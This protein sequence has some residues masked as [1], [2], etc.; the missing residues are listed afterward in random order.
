MRR[1]LQPQ[2]EASVAPVRA[3][4]AER[5]ISTD[6]S[7]A[8]R[9]MAAHIGNRADA[10][11]LPARAA[12][13]FDGR[14]SDA[15]KPTAAEV[16]GQLGAG[17]PIP[18][19]VAERFGDAY[20]ASLDHVQFHPESPVPVRHGANALTVGHHVAFA[21]GRFTP[22]TA[23]GQELIGH[24][25]A[26]VVQ[27][28]DGVQAS[29]WD[30][31][32]LEQEADAASLAVAAGHSFAIGGDRTGGVGRRV[33][34]EDGKRKPVAYDP[35][36]SLDMVYVTD[37]EGDI[38]Y[39][40]E[41]VA[42]QILASADD[43]HTL[44]HVHTN[45]RHAF[46][47]DPKFLN[48][49]YRSMYEEARGQSIIRPIPLDF[50]LLKGFS[51][52][53][54][55]A[56]AIP[57]VVYLP[58]GGGGGIFPGE[59]T[60]DPLWQEPPKVEP[61][62]LEGYTPGPSPESGH[63]PTVQYG[64]PIGKLADV[65]RHPETYDNV[66]SQPDDTRFV[67]ILDPRSS[68]ERHLIASR[69]M[70]WV[71][72]TEPLSLTLITG[73]GI[74]Q[75]PLFG[76]YKKKA[77][78]EVVGLPSLS[79]PTMPLLQPQGSGLPD[80]Q[81]LRQALTR[82]IGKS[83][84]SSP[85]PLIQG[86]SVVVTL[87]YEGPIVLIHP[88]GADG[89]QIVGTA[90]DQVTVIGGVDAKRA[91]AQGAAGYL[92]TGGAQV[93]AFAGLVRQSSE[94]DQLVNLDWM[95]KLPSPVVD[96]Q[97]DP[98]TAA[99]LG[100]DWPAPTAPRYEEQALRVFTVGELRDMVRRSQTHR[101]LDVAN[102]GRFSK[103]TDLAATDTHVL[104]LGF[105]QVPIVDTGTKSPALDVEKDFKPPTGKL[106]DDAVARVLDLFDIARALLQGNV[107]PLHPDYAHLLTSLD[108]RLG[109]LM[110]SLKAEG[111]KKSPDPVTVAKYERLITVQLE[112]M[113]SASRSI[114]QI[115]ALRSK[116]GDFW[117][118]K[119]ELEEIEA[120]YVLALAFSDRTATAGGLFEEARERLR[121]FPIMVITVVA[122]YQNRDIENTLQHT[123]DDSWWMGDLVVPTRSKMRQLSA[124]SQNQE[125]VEL[126]S[127][128]KRAGELQKEGK[129][130]EAQELIQKAAKIQESM[131]YRFAV[132]AQLH[133]ALLA[134]QAMGNSGIKYW[135]FTTNTDERLEE[136]V[137]A[138]KQ[139]LTEFEATTDDE[140]RKK[141]GEKAQKILERPRYQELY[142]DV[143]SAMK[144]GDIATGIV[145]TVIAALATWGIASGVGAVVGGS[146]L[147]GTTT[148]ALLVFGAEVVTFTAADRALMSVFMDK[149]EMHKGLVGFE[150]PQD[151]GS[152]WLED[153]LTNAAMLGMLKGVG[154]IWSGLGKN[155]GK[156]R[157]FAGEM[158]SVAAAMQT[159]GYF[160]H[161]FKTGKPMGFGQ[162][163]EMG[164]TN[165]V[166]LVLM[167]AAGMAARPL[168][169]KSELALAKRVGNYDVLTRG[170]EL[171][172][173]E[174][175]K[176]LRDAL[177]QAEKNG[178]LD[179]GKLGES[180]AEL[181]ELQNQA[182]ELRTQMAADPT[183]KEILARDPKLAESWRGRT[184]LLDTRVKVQQHLL[185]SNRLGLDP[186][187]DGSGATFNNGMSAEVA[188]FY[189]KQGFDV[190][191]AGKTPDGQRKLVATGKDGQKILLVEGRTSQNVELT[192]GF[193]R[194]SLW[195]ARNV[196]KPREDSSLEPG[197]ALVDI[198]RTP[199]GRVESVQVRHHPDVPASDVAVH[200]RAAEMFRSWGGLLGKARQLLDSI[201]MRPDRP[202]HLEIEAWKLH[203]SI[204]VRMRQMETASP[205]Q[206]ARLQGEKA[207]LQQQLDLVQRALSDPS[208]AA[209]LPKNRI[210]AKLEGRGTV[211]EPGDPPT[212]HHWT[213]QGT[214]LV[215]EP[216]EGY[217]GPRLQA[218][219]SYEHY[220][221]GTRTESRTSRGEKSAFTDRFTNTESVTMSG[222]LGKE[223]NAETASLL[224][225]LGYDVSGND[226]RARS[227]LGK[228]VY[229]E[230]LELD[231]SGK[232]Q[233]DHK[234]SAS[235]HPKAEPIAG[236]PGN[237]KLRTDLPPDQIA[238]L[239]GYPEPPAGGT[240]V[241]NRV[242]VS[243]G[244]TR[245]TL[246]LQKGR[247]ADKTFWT[248]DT[249]RG[250][251][252]EVPAAGFQAKLT[253]DGRKNPMR[254]D[255]L[256]LEAVGQGYES[257]KDRP[258]YSYDITDNGTIVVRRT[259]AAK[260]EGQP[261]L[262]IEKDPDV[263]GAYRITDTVGEPMYGA[264][265]REAATLQTM[266]GVSADLGDAFKAANTDPQVKAVLAQRDAALQRRRAAALNAPE[267]P[268]K[269]KKDSELSPKEK[270]DL[271]AWRA[272]PRVQQLKQ[273]GQAVVT[274]SEQLAEAASDAWVAV[275]F[276]G[277]V[278]L[279]TMARSARF[280]EFDRVYAWTQGEKTWIIIAECKGGSSPL[281]SRK[282]GVNRYEQGTK[283][284]LEDVALAMKE[285]GDLLGERIMKAL[286]EKRVISILVRAKVRTTIDNN[287]P[288]SS[289]EGVDVKVFDPTQMKNPP[290]KE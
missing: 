6:P 85:P 228:R 219:Y 220:L 173:R 136:L 235:E 104:G 163:A 88:T 4:I 61:L 38:S 3:K 123:G 138:L 16:A 9:T 127:L 113:G 54:L 232:I 213:T 184:E 279:G 202:F 261:K 139:I 260:A 33:Q 124:K 280:G 247:G 134:F 102:K 107:I 241:L 274:R 212:G 30:E 209:K 49:T 273:E 192:R 283:R 177:E 32:A 74:V 196:G 57:T 144:W 169:L 289:Y 182:A 248:Y 40:Q 269:G 216:N 118:L 156:G 23:Q 265:T 93:T 158:L 8:A 255:P 97:S 211:T 194:G 116:F 128:L 253:A 267:R 83:T 240:W 215:L 167:H 78:I 234:R 67:V 133:Q 10:P 36:L 92:W 130:K 272:D 96:Q 214:K 217:T 11:A 229:L 109:T 254:P 114:Q 238:R 43:A 237:P 166:A 270:S 204:D 221:P 178:K 70:R 21:P 117:E 39:E 239:L 101:L 106:D 63:D 105:D 224:G 152:G 252:V 258:G 154:R 132:L 250:D 131:Q 191:E 266:P 41:R 222:V 60:F 233:I 190:S 115:P 174:A 47:F 52:S 249:V 185:E 162:L 126:Q 80:L 48:P 91:M 46:R 45:D 286:E 122:K 276:P 20:G 28:T 186:R 34:L 201:R 203:E 135:Q 75:Q 120:L 259:D 195:K 37:W 290:K 243:G 180:M 31:G 13:Q 94:P 171:R 208:L 95:T 257:L 69:T 147:A 205:Q 87:G 27:Q 72:V 22:G 197:E 227:G 15:P 198:I 50:S 155:M 151:E 89:V 19:A 246:W 90:P 277:A 119:R 58:T 14:T 51:G 17:V 84:I 55:D 68:S 189:R 99:L 145:I 1:Y 86:T 5:A 226:I 59:P 18:G 129:N 223:L 53:N 187:L 263:E 210:W 143:A 7:C 271:A 29:G 284:Y 65:L 168:F 24:E 264:V 2:P 285:S 76:G 175:T 176:R 188:A 193:E 77:D 98:L 225:K 207:L 141:L 200:L 161:L 275:A 159:F 140:E 62:I 287:T 262:G 231:A 170:L 242:T 183:F 112:I 82:S 281:G 282:I 160:H 142:E 230:P 206:R 26:H 288:V 66:L 110:T 44:T 103:L 111:A 148:G 121:A 12:V 165:A 125:F 199:D 181:G 73:G 79:A 56:L 100:L 42:Q 244:K 256:Q 35:R 25:L 108:T 172:H 153:L 146:A 179:Q 149:S 236:V 278:R 218:E 245:P 71:S 164:G 150:D 137:A 157:R 64:D 81:K 251:W 268:V